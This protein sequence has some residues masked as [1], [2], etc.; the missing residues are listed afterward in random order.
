MIQILTLLFLLVSTSAF[1]NG[2]S[3]TSLPAECPVPAITGQ[4]ESLNYVMVGPIPPPNAKITNVTGQC[5]VNGKFPT[6]RIWGEDVD[7]YANEYIV[8]NEMNWY[9]ENFRNYSTNTNFRVIMVY[10]EPYGM[11]SNATGGECK[12]YVSWTSPTV[13]PEPKP[14]YIPAINLLLL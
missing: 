5:I 10:D 4:Y 12:I 3:L 11:P 2:G 8:T 1:A 14:K 13:E 7:G 9:T 6:T